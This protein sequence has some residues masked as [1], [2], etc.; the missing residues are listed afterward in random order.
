MQQCDGSKTD[1][2]TD[3]RN[4]AEEQVGGVGHIHSEKIS[5]KQY[6]I[7]LA[8]NFF[9]YLELTVSLMRAPY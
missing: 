5:L 6:A 7:L 9:A 4:D 8:F 2:R 3:D 1:H